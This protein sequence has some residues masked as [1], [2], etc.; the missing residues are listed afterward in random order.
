M[1]S[2]SLFSVLV[3]VIGSI[4]LE[5]ASPPPSLAASQERG[6]FVL[7]DSLLKDC[8]LYTIS[9]TG[10]KLA[11]LGFGILRTL[12]CPQIHSVG[13]VC[14]SASSFSRT[15]L[16][17][18]FFPTDSSNSFAFAWTP[19]F[20][21]DVIIFPSVLTSRAIPSIFVDCSCVTRQPSLSPGA[22]Q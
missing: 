18:H 12:R 4:A 3:L 19:S 5:R 9:T 22:H 15:T 7:I 14:Y 2:D 11:C 10:R 20:L 13:P 1:P 17:I 16:P 21:R 8:D 6:Y